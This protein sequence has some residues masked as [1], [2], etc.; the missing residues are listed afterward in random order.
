MNRF[1]RLAILLSVMTCCLPLFAQSDDEV[2]IEVK[3]VSSGIYMLIGQGGN[4][5]LSVGDDGAFLIDDQFAPLSDKIRAAVASVSKQPIRFIVN[6]HWHGD[7]TGGN[8]NFGKSGVTI[9]AHENVRK[10]MSVEQVMETFGRT[11][12]ASPNSALPILTFPDRLTFH[13]NNLEIETLH[14]APAHTDGDSMI[15]FGGANVIHMGDVFFSGMYPFIDAG[16]GGSIDGV[17][18][19][20]RMVLGRSNEET[21]IIP[22]HGPLSHTGELRE[23][24]AMLEGVRTAIL[25]QIAAGK[26]KEET[27]AANPTA[28][29]DAVWGQGFMKPDV[30]TGLVYET[31]SR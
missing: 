31:L 7:H 28:P 25:K 24:L 16:S 29:F 9:I 14:V 20:S 17:I 26:T 18:A 23:Y 21:R 13:M 3:E 6:T 27:V 2:Q 4:L 30:F 15:F 1:I 12:A 22:G 5:G 10:R 11:V 8:E 19:A